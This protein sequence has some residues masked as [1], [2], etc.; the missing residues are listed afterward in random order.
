MSI[1]EISGRPSRW[2]ALLRTGSSKTNTAGT[3]LVFSMNVGRIVRTWRPT[4][5]WLAGILLFVH[6]AM[7]RADRAS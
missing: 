7:A 6:Q 5:L 2:C 3:L 1:D 4:A